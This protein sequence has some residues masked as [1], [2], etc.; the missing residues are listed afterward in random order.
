MPN[1]IV[2]VYIFWPPS[3]FASA[4]KSW[5]LSD[6][7]HRLGDGPFSIAP[8]DE[9]GSLRSRRYIK[10]QAKD[11]ADYRVQCGHTTVIQTLA[12]TNLIPAKIPNPTPT[13]HVRLACHATGIWCELASESNLRHE[14]AVKEKELVYYACLSVSILDQLQ[15]LFMSRM[16]Y[17]LPPVKT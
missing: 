4:Q 2:K 9:T 16:Y 17:L 8:I 14:S 1:I 13:A 5:S 6:W 10:Q 7:H 11:V 3:N 12:N 15:G